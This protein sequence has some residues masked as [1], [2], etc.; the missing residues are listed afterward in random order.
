[1]RIGLSGVHR[2]DLADALKRNGCKVNSANEVKQT[3]DIEF[4]DHTSLDHLV[5]SLSDAKLN[6]ISSSFLYEHVMEF[7][8]D[9]KNYDCLV[10]VGN[11]NAEH[12]DKNKL[13]T[14]VIEYSKYSI[15]IIKIDNI[16]NETIQSLFCTIGVFK[17]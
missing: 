16:T 14:S 17:E 13:Y 1:M 9:M 15:P 10:Y 11:S 7:L 6:R 12:D 3:S 4:T 5:D 2:K 8:S